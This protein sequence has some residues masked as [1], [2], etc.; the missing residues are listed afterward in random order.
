MTRKQSMSDEEL[1]EVAESNPENPGAVGVLAALDRAA[2]ERA[3]G[4]RCVPE[5][6]ATPG[7]ID[8]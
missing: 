8:P 3:D 6:S 4:P 2:Q 5:T 7:K 1:R